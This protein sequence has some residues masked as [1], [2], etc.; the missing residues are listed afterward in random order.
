M[1]TT[2]IHFIILQFSSSWNFSFFLPNYFRHISQ[3]TSK[4]SAWESWYF[5]ECVCECGKCFHEYCIASHHHHHQRKFLSSLSIKV[6]QTFML[7]YFY[8]F[9][10]SF[11]VYFSFTAVCGA[12]AVG[13]RG[14]HK[15][16]LTFVRKIRKIE[17]IRRTYEWVSE[18]GWKL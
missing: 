11:V 4:K 14:A 9:L 8:Y 10:F 6:M 12:R 13:A 1:K 2:E 16:T 3:S 5:S 18:W 17:E 7:K 15:K